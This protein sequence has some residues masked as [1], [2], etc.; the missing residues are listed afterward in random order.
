[1]Q[2]KRSY[3]FL[4]ASMH[5]GVYRLDCRIKGFR[6]AYTFMKPS[7]ILPIDVRHPLFTMPTVLSFSLSFSLSFLHSLFVSFL[8]FSVCLSVSLSLFL[9]DFQEAIYSGAAINIYVENHFPGLK[10][11]YDIYFTCPSLPP[12]VFYKR[13]W[14]SLFPF[15]FFHRPLCLW[16][17]IIYSHLATH[18]SWILVG[19]VWVGP[20]MGYEDFKP[21]LL[22]T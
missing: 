13:I 14:K 20:Y 16:L 18:K 8:F 21:S 12:R 9:S 4:N 15:N 11:R 17:C 5:K 7:V 3:I 6:C 10:C 22:E 19:W 1:M 2:F